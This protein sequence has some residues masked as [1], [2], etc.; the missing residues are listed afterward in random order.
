MASEHRKKKN[1]FLVQG[2]ILAL[3][4]IIVRVIGLFYRVPMINILG[5][6]GSGIYSS[7]FN[8]Y[9]ILLLLSSS[10]LPLA[11]SKMIAERTSKGEFRNAGAVL[12]VSLIFSFFLGGATFCI[13][14]FGSDFFASAVLHAPETA[15]AIRTLAPTIFI[16]A[17]LSTFRGFFQGL[18]TM[19]PTAVS[20]IIEQIF[21]AVFSIVCAWSLFNMGMAAEGGSE[22]LAAAWGA[23]G[24]TIGT[25]VGA[26]SALGFVLF[27]WLIYRKR[28]NARVARDRT[29]S[30]ESGLSILKIVVL[31]ALPIMLSGT[32]SNISTVLDQSFYGQYMETAGLSD[33]YMSIWGSYSSIYV[34][35]TTLP[36]A[37]S[38][39]LASSAAPS[40]A[41]ANV[42]GKKEELLSKI[43]SSIRFVMIIA[44]PSTVGLTVLSAPI[45]QM[46]F[47][48]DNGTG[49]HML[50]VGSV[51]VVFASTMTITNAVLQGIGH[52]VLPLRNS[53]IALGA[54]VLFLLAALRMDTGIYGVMFATIFFNIVITVLNMIDI[55]RLLGYR[56]ELVRTVLLPLICSAVMGA[57]CWLVREGVYLLLHSNMLSVL[58]ALVAA[59]IV[60]A[61]LLLLSRAVTEDE[62]KTFPMGTRITGIAKRLR[63]M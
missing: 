61:V 32:I 28:F 31:S 12:R 5:D 53:A 11:I 25:G 54:H 43:S 51:V 48:I 15:F 16:M 26:L 8:I 4:G 24:G 3:A 58:A 45:V 36:I 44:L 20:Q 50:L 52:M 13:V 10:S 41:S 23:G 35:L 39:A 42:T 6:E 30:R 63:L 1:N 57:A 37:I 60:Y 21:N 17:F 22:H 40:I 29:G 18:G 46:F 9:S 59:V 19:I 2:G 49:A 33:V 27:I 34:L 62:L 38:T 55:H 14:W 56:Q 47:P 7:A